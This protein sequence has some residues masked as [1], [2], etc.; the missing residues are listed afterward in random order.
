V[1]KL[2]RRVCDLEANVLFIEVADGC[3]ILL[4]N[5]LLYAWIPMYPISCQLAK[6]SCNVT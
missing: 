6:A 2:Q 5:L 1:H 3:L 4:L